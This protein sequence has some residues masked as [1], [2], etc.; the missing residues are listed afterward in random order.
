MTSHTGITQDEAIELTIESIPPGPPPL[1]TCVAV[2][3]AAAA[4]ATQVE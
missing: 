3:N 1:A 2:V 4:S